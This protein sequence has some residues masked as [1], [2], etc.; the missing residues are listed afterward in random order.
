M[1]IV[2]SIETHPDRC[3]NEFYGPF[4]DYESARA[5]ADKCEA[6]PGNYNGK[7]RLYNFNVE[8]LM[9]VTKD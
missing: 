7:H 9:Q 4:E 8:N 2:Y 5:F 6:K 3:L 1:Y